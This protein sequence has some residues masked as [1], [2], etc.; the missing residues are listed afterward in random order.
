MTRWFSTR[1][2]GIEAVIKEFLVHYHQARPH[3]GVDQR[4]PDPVPT[5]IPLPVVSKIVRNDRLGG[6]LHEYAWVP[7]RVDGEMGLPHTCR[8]SQQL[9]GHSRTP[10]RCGGARLAERS[11]ALVGVEIV[12]QACI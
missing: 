3:Q 1:V 8:Q 2:T 12:C 6:L 7:D 11:A 10:A 4:W 5:V 9:G